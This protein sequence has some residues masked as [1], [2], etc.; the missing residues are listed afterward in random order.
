MAHA[1]TM[2]DVERYENQLTPGWGKLMMWGFLC[3]DAMSFAGLLAAYG[4]VRLG[5][6]YW[7]VPPSKL[8][9][10]LTALHTLLPNCTSLSNLKR[11]SAIKP[12]EPKGHPRVLDA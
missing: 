4:A 12:G 1:A 10:P 3:S 8:D 6:H 9:V 7:P 2:N 5:S 11:L